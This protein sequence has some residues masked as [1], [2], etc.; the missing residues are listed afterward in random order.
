MS[1]ILIVAY[2]PKPGKRQEL[3]EL[4]ERQHCHGCELKLIANPLPWLGEGVHGEVVSIVGL[5][6]GV[7]IDALWE[8]EVAQD[9]DARIAAIAVMSPLRTLYEANAAFVDIA[10]IP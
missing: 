9:I 6:T 3:L 4:L 1:R 5:D 8:D 10:A 7:S 2:R